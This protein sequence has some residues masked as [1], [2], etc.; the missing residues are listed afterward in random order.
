MVFK[1]GFQVCGNRLKAQTILLKPFYFI[2]TYPRLSNQILNIKDMN[3]G[4]NPTLLFLKV[5]AVIVLF[6]YP[7]M[8]L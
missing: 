7:E 5:K 3:L 2:L 1:F 6:L 8:D 4:Q